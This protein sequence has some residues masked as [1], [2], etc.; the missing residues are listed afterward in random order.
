MSAAS[1][2]ANAAVSAL[3]AAAADFVLKRHAY[4]EALLASSQAQDVKIA[5]E[6]VLTA[7]QTEVDAAIADLQKEKS[8]IVDAAK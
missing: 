2:R 8:D 5:A 7:A 6:N 4:T 3:G 1:D